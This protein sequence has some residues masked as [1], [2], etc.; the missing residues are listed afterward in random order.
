MSQTQKESKQTW[1]L[2]SLEAMEDWD[3]PDFGREED[4]TPA[5]EVAGLWQ[6]WSLMLRMPANN[7]EAISKELHSIREDLLELART[8]FTLESVEPARPGGKNGYP[9]E[10]DQARTRLMT[11]I[12][13]IDKV[14]GADQETRVT[15]ALPGCLGKSDKPEIE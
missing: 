9:Q 5:D 6:S 1:D 12:H 15:F 2:Q 10:W 8:E 7:P 4:I 3:A 14:T 13:A 11:M